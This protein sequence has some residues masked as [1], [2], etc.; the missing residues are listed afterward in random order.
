MNKY[1]FF[2]AATAATVTVASF[3]APASAADHAD[4][5]F[6]FTDVGDRY[7]EAVEFLYMIEA[8][9][10]VS[11]TKFG[12]QQTLT[13]GDAAV[14]LSNLLGLDTESA[15]DAGFKD[16]NTRV[17]GSVNALVEYGVVSGV[18]KTEF[19]P[20]E[21]LSRGAMAK[22]LVT[23]FELQD[24][25]EETP[26]TDVGGVF[27]PY[28]EALY[29]TGITNGKTATSYGTYQNITR[30]EFANL[31][32]AAVMFEFENSYYPVPVKATVTSATSTQVV[33]EEAVPDDY[34]PGEIASLLYFSL[35]YS[36]GTENEINPTS[37]TLSADRMTLTIRHEDLT[38]KKGT[39]LVS[40]FEKEIVAP[41]NFEPVTATSSAN[42]KEPFEQPAGVP[43]TEAAQ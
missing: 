7:A 13:R 2:T 9:N 14:I 31:L 18:T 27:Q 6:P 42:V 39:M 29:G 33:L 1:T 12:T 5:E 21:P 38:G 3:S 4:Y 32:Y 24:Y 34:T 41:F 40:D 10:G 28:I 26:F 19:K 22:F 8:I 35:D 16:L 17:K 15:P 23:A 37:Y 25:A 43:A 11:E 36:D 20:G 30:G